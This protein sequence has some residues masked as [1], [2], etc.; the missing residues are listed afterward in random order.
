MIPNKT[1]EQI[2]YQQFKFFDL[3]STG[4]CSLQNFVR[5]QNRV[6]VVLPKIKDFEL[7][8]N[9]FAEPESFLLDYRKFC[10]EIFNFDHSKQIQDENEIEEDGDFISIIIHKILSKNGPFTLLEIIKNL[11]IIDFEGNKRLNSDE[12]LTALQRSGIKLDVKDIQSLFCGYD[13]FISGVIKYQIF[14]D[15]LLAQF[16]N[17]K[18]NS[19]SEEIF[20]NLTN[21]GRKQMTLNDI[22]NYFD[23]IL[24]DSPDKKNLLNF[25]DKYKVI[26]KNR[27]NQNLIL[28]DMI[29][30]LQFY[31]FGENSSNFLVNMLNILEPDMPK[32]NNLF[33][34]INNFE[35]NIE[36]KN[37]IKYNKKIT[38][39]SNDQIR[40]IFENL[41][42]KIFNYSRKTFFN[43]IKHFKY[44]DENSNDITIYNFSKVLKDFNLNISIDDIE[45]IFILYGYNQKTKTINYKDFINDLISEFTDEKRLKIIRY[46]YDTIEERGNKFKRDIDLTFLKEVYNAKKNYFKKDEAENRLEYEDCLELFHYIYKG[47]KSELFNK[48]DFVE[49]YKCISFLVYS[50]NEFMKLISNEWRVPFEYIQNEILENNNLINNCVN[51]EYN[52]DKNLE[53]NINRERE[54]DRER[55]IVEKI[56]N[57]EM[58]RNIN[59]DKTKNNEDNIN[60]YPKKSKL[61]EKLIN[62]DFDND[63]NYEDNSPKSLSLLNNILKRRGLRGILYLHLE[64]I[65][66]CQDLSRISF[67]DFMNIIEIQ[68][69]KLS[70]PDCKNI[71]NQFSSKNNKNYLD[72]SSFIRNF[73]IELNENKLSLVEDAFNKIDING[74][75][76]IPLNLI[77]KRFKAEGHPDVLKGRKNEED[78][79]LEFLDCF[80]I[81]YEILNLD[82]KSQTSNNGQ[83]LIDFE[84][85]ANFYEYLSFLYPDDKEFNYIVS[86]CWN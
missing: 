4:Y 16:W 65:N 63:N 86:S 32:E 76:R 40:N 25:I 54:R 1:N 27:I 81:N 31:G 77:K 57:K 68:H 43:F 22:K 59:N 8:F 2:L 48:N 38:E 66:S 46:I 37:K 19:L 28:P 50:D 34:N 29:K 45:K 30:F 69:I 9:Y 33:N 44:Y 7:I 61:I 49:F 41:R 71:F 80:N 5:V 35:E 67:N 11:Q 13:F 21:G 60:N 79:I 55:D 3:D 39:N 56:P 78:I 47:K 6:G 85:F 15:I 10:K 23:K 42:E 14:I 53:R 70:E 62:N 12:F 82:S 83:I 51:E 18:K 58:N 64:F 26:N 73:K 24:E 20:F 75:D 52:N 74:N 36:P 84:I 17:E 72:F